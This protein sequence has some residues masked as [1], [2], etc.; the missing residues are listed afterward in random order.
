MDARMDATPHGRHSRMDA[1]P[2]GHSRMDRIYLSM[3]P[4]PIDQ[5]CCRVECGRV[6]TPGLHRPWHGSRRALE[7]QPIRRENAAAGW[8]VYLNGVETRYAVGAVER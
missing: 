4:D 8:P 2:A 6:S 7:R 5:K 1:T 3:E